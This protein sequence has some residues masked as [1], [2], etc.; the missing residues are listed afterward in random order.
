MISNHWPLP[1]HRPAVE[2]EAR[3][4]DVASQVISEL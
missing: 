2:L 3:E 1:G 4:G